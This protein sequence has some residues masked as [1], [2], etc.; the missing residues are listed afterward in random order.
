MAR[1]AGLGLLGLDPAW[2]RGRRQE[3]HVSLVHQ[4]RYD[5]DADLLDWR[6]G[7]EAA[8]WS[9]GMATPDAWG[10]WQEDGRTVEF[11]MEYDRGTAALRRLAGDLAG[12]E[13]FEH[14]RGV[15][16]WVLF[17]FTSARREQTARDALT[18]A[19]VPVATATL[20]DDARPAGQRLAAPERPAAPPAAVGTGPRPQAAGSRRTG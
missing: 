18:G 10:V 6:T 2:P 20:P 8:Q 7:P 9:Q 16:A 5:R 12:Y 1:R 3:F 14:D 19:T 4:A 13:R 17:A 11:F 15:T